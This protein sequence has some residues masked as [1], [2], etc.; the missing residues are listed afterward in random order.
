MNGIGVSG[1]LGATT[2]RDD[3]VI[4]EAHPSGMDV[5]ARSTEEGS[6]TP[7]ALRA[8]GGHTATAAAACS[9]K[10]EGSWSAPRSSSRWRVYEMQSKG[11]RS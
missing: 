1:S 11:I 9:P 7:A 8:S 6:A 4:R 10:R 5:T 3:D 2:T